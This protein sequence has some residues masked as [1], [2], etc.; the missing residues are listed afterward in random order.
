MPGV[1][2]IN[3]ANATPL[4]END[5]ATAVRARSTLVGGRDLVALIVKESDR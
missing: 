2:D 5:M 3:E 4:T 1:R